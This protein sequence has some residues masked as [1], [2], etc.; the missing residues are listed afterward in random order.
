M[1]CGTEFR[2][3]D[4]QRRKSDVIGTLERSFTANEAHI[5]WQRAASY[6]FQQHAAEL[7]RDIRV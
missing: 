2:D 4:R 1:K 3:L 5:S 7:R 6:G